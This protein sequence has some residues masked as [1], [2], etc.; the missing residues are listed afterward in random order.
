MSEFKRARSEAQ[1][2]ERFEEV[3]SVTAK[4]F[5]KLPYHEITL[6]TIGEQLGWTRANV[7]K[8][9]SSKE[10][11][12]LEL[13][14]DARDAYFNDLIKAFSKDK[15]FSQDEVA[16]KWASI[17]D[18]NRKWAMYGAILVSIIEE[19]VS[20]ERLKEFKGAYYDEL[21]MLTQ[22][23][24]PNIGISKEKF[25]D[26]FSAIHYH[27]CGLS[28]ICEQNPLV[29]QAIKELGIKRNQVNFKKDMQRF[30]GICLQGYS[31]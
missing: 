23:V 26:C 20:I 24:A 1:K 27:A 11:I 29:K 10:E 12:F 5:E 13:S 17:F 22:E 3:K 30:I 18:K 6:S 16:K 28:G 21:E 31:D 9:F 7:Y 14:A 25:V 19:N 15:G 8:Y 2:Q 4:L